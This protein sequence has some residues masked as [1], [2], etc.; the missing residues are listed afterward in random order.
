M[1]SENIVRKFI[2]QIKEKHKG[3]SESTIEKDFY[4]TLLLNEISK[5]IEEN[6]KSLFSKLVFKGGT[7]FILPFPPFYPFLQPTYPK[8][9][10]IFDNSSL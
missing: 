9:P 3:V 2:A 5:K 1:V 8:H 6:K 7:L 4:L 10:S